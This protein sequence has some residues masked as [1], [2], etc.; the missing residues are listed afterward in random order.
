MRAAGGDG[1]DVEGSFDDD[2][3]SGVGVGGLGF[4]EA[5]EQG[6]FVEDRRLAAVEVL[7]C[8]FGAGQVAADEPGDP[9]IL[10]V[11]GEDDAVVEGVDEGAA[12]GALGQ[13]GVEQGLV[14]ERAVQAIDEA[15][16]AG[17]RV[18]QW[19]LLGQG[20]GVDAAL[21]QVG[22]RGLATRRLG[23]DRR[24]RCGQLLQ[25]GRS[26]LPVAA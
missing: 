19:P 2:G 25:R 22:E 6:A 23:E 5:V 9:T 3:L 7:R 20:G 13:S 18:T 10:V 1:E 15:G 24:R 26:R 21:A 14:V 17:W 4:V 16:P 11:D 12:A 8:L